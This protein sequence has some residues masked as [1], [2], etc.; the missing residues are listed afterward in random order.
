MAEVAISTVVHG[1]EDG[2]RLEFA[3][4]EEVTGLDKETLD[5][6]RAAGSIGPATTLQD[7]NDRQAL[8]DKIAELQAELN[9]KTPQAPSPAPNPGP[10]APV[11]ATPTTPTKKA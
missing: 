5:Q 1:T 11:K 4:G 10:V 6:L 9:D 8:L 3:P 2:E 7:E